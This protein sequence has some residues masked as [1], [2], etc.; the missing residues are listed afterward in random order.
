V[1]DVGTVLAAISGSIPN[2]EYRKAIVDH[3]RS[4]SINVEEIP[5][6]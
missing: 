4:M 2:E 3:W 1:T 6:Q 5:A